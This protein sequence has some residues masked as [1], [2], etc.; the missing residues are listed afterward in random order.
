[1][2]RED[3][4]YVGKVFLWILVILLFRLLAGGKGVVEID[5]TAVDLISFSMRVYLLVNS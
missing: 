5:V 3:V 4:V 2:A 1:M